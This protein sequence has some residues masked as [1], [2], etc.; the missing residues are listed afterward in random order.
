MNIKKSVSNEA[1]KED[2]MKILWLKYEHEADLPE[3]QVSSKEV[4]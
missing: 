4:K 2:Q 3:I 1:Y